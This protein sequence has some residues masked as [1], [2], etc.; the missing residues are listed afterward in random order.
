MPYVFPFTDEEC[1]SRRVAGGKGA[2]LAELTQFGLPVPAG[3]C[4]GVSA[5]S[6]FLV[7]GGLGEELERRITALP[8]DDPV[9]LDEQTEQIRRL[10]CDAEMPSDLS[11]AVDLAYEEFAE[12]GY[13]AV[14]SSGTAED[15]PEESFAGL[16]DTLL[17][18]LGADGVRTA[19]KECW[20]SLWTARAVSYRHDKGF[21][22]M[23]VK[24]AVVVQRMVD[25]ESS[26]VLFTG[27]PVNAA[28]D[29]TVINASWG[30]GEA[31]VQGIV[32]PD[33]YVTESRT[34]RLLDRTLGSKETQV[35]RDAAA[36]LGTTMQSVPDA[37]RKQFV[38][39]DSQL[40]ELT[41]LG[42]RIQDNYGGFPQDVEW[43]FSNG[44]LWLLQS[45]RIT[46]VEFSWDA[47]INDD[48]EFSAPDDTVW[49]RGYADELYTGVITPINFTLRWASANRRTRWGAEV[50]GFNDLIG[51]SCFTYHKGFVYQNAHAEKRWLERT[52]L[53]FLR[54]YMLDL[55]P[56]T[57]RSELKDWAPLSPWQYM[58]MVARIA[59]RSPENFRFTQTLARWRRP[60]LR[61][62]VSGY[63]REQAG[64]LTDEQLIA[65]V[66]D[67]Q[68]LAL[69]YTQESTF[70]FQI[71]F[72]QACAF[73]SWIFD[74]WYD[75]GDPSLEADL[76]SG[77]RSRTETQIE[78]LRLWG[79]GVRLRESAE[80]RALIEEH[81]NEAFFDVVRRSDVPAVRS[82]GQ[83]Y[84]KFLEEYGFRGHADR[85]LIYPRREED[86]SIDYRTLRM[87][88][89]VDSP[90]DPERT[91]RETNE[92]RRSAYAQVVADLRR[93]GPRGWG[94]A[95]VFA[96]LYRYL[97][98]FIVY[99]DNVRFR[100]TDEN[101]VA[102][103]NGVL[104]VGQRLHDRGVLDAPDDIY[105]IT[106]GDACALLR[107][108]QT[109]TA[110]LEAKVAARRSDV[111]RVLAKEWMPPMFLRQGRFIDLDY[112]IDDSDG[113]VLRGIPTSKGR[114]TANARVVR[115]LADIGR[116]RS[117]DI[118]VTNSTDPGWT[119]VFLLLSGV[120]VETGGVLSHA[121]CLAREYGLPAVQLSH[122]TELI[123]DGATITL[124]GDTGT[125]IIE[126]D[127]PDESSLVSA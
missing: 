58:H 118:L 120:V 60:A 93:R 95:A 105:Y 55:I 5:Y 70:Q 127:Q 11:Q 47:E 68:D 64:H 44:S 39:S 32:V 81:E 101:A 102:Q 82:F 42:Q 40:A 21:D 16:H 52:T 57:W 79:L 48:P 119:P 73:L 17:D 69:E 28:V 20:A 92:R 83:D 65:Y 91:E 112:P 115:L 110:L 116:V 25:S 108:Q 35:I 45:R 117:G 94:R 63:T 122:G 114:V 12:G 7:G 90:I 121:S 113:G 56:P 4:V 76:L 124:N 33:Q 29:Q 27:D 96:L 100:P 125:V 10:L 41:A 26:G 72:R 99:R 19:I 8:L 3:F 31:I 15:L 46:G 98:K 6:D 38:L 85:D 34:G 14:R 30:L 84:D 18:V 71:F 13:V 77:A 107:G 66:Q 62:R 2:T 104:E 86:P 106:W 109:R 74:H 88:A 103:K 37:M 126:A 1:R 111:A 80:L 22:Q 54:P 89:T 49:N 61:T 43:A 24:I 59:L 23:Q 97:Q 53:P 67:R 50:C 78:N 51:V 9:A 123:P 36:G 75:E 87:F